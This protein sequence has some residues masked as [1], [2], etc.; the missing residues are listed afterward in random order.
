MLDFTEP[1]V[2]ELKRFTKA[3]FD[4]GEIFD[5]ARELKY[6]SEIKRVLAEELGN[7]SGAFVRFI[8]GRVYQGRVTQK[9]REWFKPIAKQAFADFI[10]DRINIRLKS[11]LEREEGQTLVDDEE[12]PSQEEQKGS[13]EFVP[14]ELEALYIIKAIVRDM[15]DVHRIGLRS[16]SRFCSVLLDDNMFKPVC[17]LRLRTSNL[18][19]GLLDEEK[20]EE[21]VQLGDLDDLYNHSDSLRAAV[22][23]YASQGAEA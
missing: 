4:L 15:V 1:Q 11:A 12:S 21:S 18:R 23:R 2:E 19:L 5:A 13:D 22:T 17:R 3:A 6:T 9:M 8:I 10:N 14:A 20:R 7:P 16:Y